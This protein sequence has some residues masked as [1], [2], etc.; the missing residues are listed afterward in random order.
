MLCI[1]FETVNKFGVL[2]Y[3]FNII[4]TFIFVH[5]NNYKNNTTENGFQ[6]YP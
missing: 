2:Q 1:L 3:K 5:L 6:A 4:I